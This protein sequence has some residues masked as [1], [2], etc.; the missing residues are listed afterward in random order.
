VSVTLLIYITKEFFTFCLN[1][2]VVIFVTNVSCR[3][4]GT[5][6]FMTV[7]LI[8]SGWTFVKHILSDRDKKIF[9]IVIPLQVGVMLCLSTEVNPFDVLPDLGERC[10]DHH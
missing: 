3:M 5:L 8:G 6:L 7:V 4:K 2:S 1:F 10:P 9:I